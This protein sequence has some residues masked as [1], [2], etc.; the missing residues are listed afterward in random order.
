MNNDRMTL[1]DSLRQWVEAS[2]QNITA[3]ART[4][5]VAQPVLSRFMNGERDMT[6]R[7]ADRL[8]AHFGL[9]PRP[10]RRK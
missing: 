9:E 2:G 8:A 10:R 1:A 7:V 3:V 6:L 5:G 4:A